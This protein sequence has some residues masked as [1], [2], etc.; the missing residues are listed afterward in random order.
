[1]QHG[2]IHL[3]LELIKRYFPTKAPKIE[4]YVEP[5]NAEMAIK[6]SKQWTI[7]TFVLLIVWV[8]GLAYFIGQEA[9][10]LTKYLI[11]LNYKDAIVINF[12]MV[13]YLIIGFVA[14]IYFDFFLDW[15]VIKLK[16]EETLKLLNYGNQLKSDYNIKALTP[17]LKKA[18]FIFTFIIF[19]LGGMTHLRLYQDRFVMSTAIQDDEV[20]PFNQI[21]SITYAKSVHFSNGDNRNTPIIEIKMKDNIIWE[22]NDFDIEKDSFVFKLIEQRAHIKIDS[23]PSLYKE[24]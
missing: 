5:I 3:V 15:F 10:K 4:P 23:I 2:I 6:V 24:K 11:Q 7:P 17:L 16:D 14:A 19:I 22:S 1:M 21:S 20:Y 9:A 13:W 12:P 8:G 18:V